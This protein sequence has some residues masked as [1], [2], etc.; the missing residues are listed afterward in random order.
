MSRGHRLA[1]WRDLL[2]RY[3]TV[4]RFYWKKRGSME[5]GL[6]NAQEA[7][8]LPGALSLQEK[9]LSPVA[10]LTIW[11]LISLVLLI[12]AWSIFGWIDIVVNGTGKVIV[13]GRTKTVASVEVAS[14]RA[15]HVHEGQ[16]VKAGDMLVELDSAAV[17]AERDKARTEYRAALLLAARSRALIQAVDTMTP[18]HLPALTGIPEEQWQMEQRHLS[19]QFRD[20]RAKL[21]SLDSEIKRY[22]LALPLVTRQAQD[23]RG[24]AATHDVSLHAYLTKE[25]AR[26]DI[27]SQLESAR[28]QRN[29]LITQTKKEAQDALTEGT[30][31]AESARQDALRATAHKR[32]LTLTAPVDGTVQQLSMHTVGGVVPAAQPI[33]LVVPSDARVEVEA[34]LENKDIGFVREGQRAAVKIDAFEYTKYGTVPGQVSHV[35]HDAIEDEKRGLIYAVKVTLDRSSLLIDGRKV[36]LT[37]GMSANVEIKTGERRIIEYVLSPLL[38]H[39]RESLRER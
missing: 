32:L 38:Q 23:L 28:D 4:F 9:P 10:H 17:D 6:F 2:H 29:S 21:T 11:L 30:R 34:M 3:H 25:Q 26:L 36:P 22:R 18:P 16:K 13:S 24:L 12:L 14:V 31:S 37:P 35:S 5:S 15:L 8:F 19:D 27:A 7:E 20:F 39:Q 1:A 33:M